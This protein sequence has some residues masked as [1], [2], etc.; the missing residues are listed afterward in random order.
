ME[1]NKILV[2]DNDKATQ[3]WLSTL[4]SSEGYEISIASNGEEF[5][6]KFDSEQP[7]LV[8]L[9]PLFPDMEYGLVFDVISLNPTTKD[10]PIIVLSNDDNPQTIASMFDKGASDYIVKR[11]HIEN[12]ILGKC[13]RFFHQITP[14][15]PLSVSGCTVS[16]FSPKGGIGTNR[17]GNHT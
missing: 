15:S 5:I 11:P 12:E 3:T 16:F 10:I 17:A 2:V 4:L 1:N 13:A 6:Q 8:I 9:D 14:K 7:N